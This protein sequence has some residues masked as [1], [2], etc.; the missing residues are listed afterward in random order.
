MGVYVHVHNAVGWKEPAGQNI[1]LKIETLTS[2]SDGF[3]DN[4]PRW[5]K[6]QM[7]FIPC[8]VHCVVRPVHCLPINVSK[9][10]TIFIYFLNVCIEI[11]IYNTNH[12]FFHIF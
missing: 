11:N 6:L 3:R 7:Y 4:K 10:K 12:I 5:E 2:F 9:E 1:K 8:I